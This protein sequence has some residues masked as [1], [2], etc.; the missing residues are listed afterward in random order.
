MRF[1][2]SLKTS[3][4]EVPLESQSE[5]DGVQSSPE[6]GIAM[7]S[8][9]L[10]ALSR[11]PYWY[12]RPF[13]H[14]GTWNPTDTALKSAVSIS[15]SPKQA[16]SPK[17]PIQWMVSP[18]YN[19]PSQK[20][21]WLFSPMLTAYESYGLTSV[22]PLS[23]QPPLRSKPPSSGTW[24]TPKLSHWSPYSLHKPSSTVTKGS[25]NYTHLLLWVS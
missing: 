5:A 18:S 19:H 7:V 15:P 2:Y 12:Y 11:G 14:P 6:T 10:L 20:P 1:E 23:P 17:L 13:C 21:G 16:R 25:F 24:M 4:V 9:V 8:W 22:L 3:I